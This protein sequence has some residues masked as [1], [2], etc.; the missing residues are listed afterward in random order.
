MLVS[1]NDRNHTCGRC[2]EAIA[3]PLHSTI[4]PGGPEIYQRYCSD[5]VSQVVNN[6]NNRTAVPAELQHMDPASR[7]AMRITRENN[8]PA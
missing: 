8:N 5:C 6:P 7:P 1:S 2:N 4:G 3:V